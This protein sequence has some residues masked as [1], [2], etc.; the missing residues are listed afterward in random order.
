ML[1]I[2]DNYIINKYIYILDDFSV[3]LFFV[4]VLFCYD[5]EGFSTCCISLLLKLGLTGKK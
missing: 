2:Q 4:V 5:E 3:C 1:C